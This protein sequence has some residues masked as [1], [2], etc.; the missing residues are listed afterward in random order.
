[1]DAAVNKLTPVNT[2]K[3]KDSALD[4]MKNFALKKVHFKLGN[5]HLTTGPNSKIFHFQILQWKYYE[6]NA[7]E[8]Q[9]MQKINPVCQQKAE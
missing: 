2:K 5:L 1:M 4:S 8:L 9:E 6:V 7:L 3:F